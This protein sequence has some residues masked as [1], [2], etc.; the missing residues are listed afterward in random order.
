MLAMA[1]K[2]GKVQASVPGLADFAKVSLEECQE[3]IKHLKATDPYSRTKDHDGRRIEDCE[4]GWII[5]NHALYREKMREEER[6]NYLTHKQREYRVKKGKGP[7]SRE[8]IACKAR[9]EG[10]DAT[11]DSV[12]EMV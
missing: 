8:Q 11:A 7:G 9:R 1:D 2:D 6:R 10:D 5:L 12:E 4:G 3:A